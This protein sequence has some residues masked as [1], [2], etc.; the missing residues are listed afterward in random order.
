MTLYTLNQ[1]VATDNLDISQPVLAANT[2]AADAVFGFEHYPFSNM[3]ANQGLHNTVTTPGYVDSP[4][5]NLPPV[6]TTEPIFYGYTP[7]NAMTGIAT[8]NLPVIQW[9]RGVMNAVPSP[10]TTL[11]STLAGITI[12][13][14]ASVTIFDFAGMNIAMANLYAMANAASFFF[15]S[16]PIFFN[17]STLQVFTSGLGGLVA[18]T[19][20]GTQLQL[21][22][23]TG[24]A[25]TTNVYW[26]IEFARI[27]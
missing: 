5:T 21:K 23:T 10:L 4:V 9:S 19:N 12:N 8:T 16:G 18:S 2:N 22:N 1:P 20:G 24:G 7:L 13:A 25:F 17:G 6:T 3:T 26:T 27:Q 15:T 11:Q 14:G